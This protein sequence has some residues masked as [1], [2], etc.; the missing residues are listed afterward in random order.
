M[1]TDVNSK[2]NKICNKLKLSKHSRQGQSSAYIHRKESDLHNISTLL[3]VNVLIVGIN[4]CLWVWFRITK[5][6]KRNNICINLNKE[7]VLA[8]MTNGILRDFEWKR[9][10]NISKWRPLVVHLIFRSKFQKQRSHSDNNFNRI[11]L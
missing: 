9:V 8:Q 5:V 10:W 6:Y 4:S 7:L 11:D 2:V 3:T 1:P